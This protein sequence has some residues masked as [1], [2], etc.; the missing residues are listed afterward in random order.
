MDITVSHCKDWIWPLAFRTMSV[1]CMQVGHRQKQ[2]GLPW[3]TCRVASPM[4]AKGW[5]PKHAVKLSLGHAHWWGRVPMCKLANADPGPKSMHV[6]M[7]KSIRSHHLKLALSFKQEFS[8]N[9]QPKTITTNTKPFPCEPYT[10]SPSK[11]LWSRMGHHDSPRC[12]RSI[13]HS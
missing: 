5:V 8:W 1:D 2:S 4:W 6:P 7:C 12:K 11:L 3:I 10:G 13:C 9:Y